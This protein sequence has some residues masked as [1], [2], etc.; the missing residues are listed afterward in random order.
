MAFRVSDFFKR[1]FA[2]FLAFV[3][4]VIFTSDIIQLVLIHKLAVECNDMYLVKIIYHHNPDFGHLVSV[5]FLMM[6]SI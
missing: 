4:I 6:V 1:T 3:H 2:T 5:A